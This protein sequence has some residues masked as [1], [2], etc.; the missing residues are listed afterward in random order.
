MWNG[1]PAKTKQASSLAIFKKFIYILH[2]F[3]FS[4][5]ILG[6]IYVIRFLAFFYVLDFRFKVFI[7]L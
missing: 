7:A 1:L 4:F 3:L 5:P 6:F 2:A